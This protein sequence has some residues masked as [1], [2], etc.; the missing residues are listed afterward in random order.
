MSHILRFASAVTDHETLK[1][2]CDRMRADGLAVIGPN[3]V[4]NHPRPQNDK[5]T[6]DG[7]AVR[8]PGWRSDCV[9]ACDET[10]EAVADNWSPYFDYRKIDPRSGERIAGTGDVHKDVLS[11]VKRPGDNGRWGDIAYLDRLNIECRAVAVENA[12]MAQGGTI[13]Y[14]SLD[15]ETG[16]LTMT[17][18]VPEA[19]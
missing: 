12:A 6:I 1:V 16:V 2:A 17:I 15:E 7:Y 8:L 14:R 4:T 13:S 19:L 18:D 5:G 10:G 11:G 3:F 9:F